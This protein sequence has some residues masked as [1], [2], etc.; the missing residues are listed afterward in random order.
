[1]V[2]IG[3]RFSKVSDPKMIWEVSKII[4]S[5]CLPT[6]ARIRGYSERMEDSILIS[7]NVLLDNS[8][9]VNHS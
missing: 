1:M 5:K 7:V 3:D 9:Y 4:E 2:K 6:H 8:L